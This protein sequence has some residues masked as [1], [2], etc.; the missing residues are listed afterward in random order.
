MGFQADGPE[1][2]ELGLALDASFFWW[3]GGGNPEDQTHG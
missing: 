2:E 1:G 3:V